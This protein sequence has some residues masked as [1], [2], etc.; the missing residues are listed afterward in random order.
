V[1]GAT[2]APRPVLATNIA[3]I[4]SAYKLPDQLVRLVRKLDSD[5]SSFFIHV[6]KKTDDST[7]GR[8]SA[9]LSGSPNVHFLSRHRCDYGGFGHVRAT[10]KGIVELF[11]R[12]L[13]FDYVVLLTGQ[14]YPIKSNRQIL[15]FFVRHRGQS[16][17]EYFPLPYAEWEHGGMDRLELRHVRLLGRHLRLRRTDSGTFARRFPSLKLFGGSAYWCLSSE[18]AE[19]VCRFVRDQPS[20]ERFFKNVD[21]PDE[22]F[23]QTIVMNSPLGQRVVND[24]LR[25]VEWRNSAIAGG[26][27]VL[28]A[29][30][31]GKIA[32]S[33]KLFARKFDITKDAEILDL[34]DARTSEDRGA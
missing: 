6:D 29:E 4:I 24:D 26:P 28:G 32:S 8:V 25:F 33:S 17:L 5:G 13:S 3:Y 27:A 21:V 34:I 18:C 1:T 15:D 23:F 19:Y 16:F 10:I 11:R 12:E 7:F 14:D 2:D 9:A 30:D 22:I 20:Y 31:F